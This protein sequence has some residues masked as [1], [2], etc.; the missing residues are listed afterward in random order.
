M[1]NIT[2]IFVSFFYIGYLKIWPGSF[3]SAASIII[4]FSILSFDILSKVLFIILFIIIFFLSLYF[5]KIFSSYTKTH[6]SGIIV[7]DEFLGIYLIL[8]FYDLIIFISPI[9]TLI[10]AFM[11]FRFFDILK[12]YPANLI[13]KKMNNSLGVILDD[14]VAAI[15]TIISIY[16]L[17]VVN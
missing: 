17:N 8:I 3:A 2:K 11:L 12:I 16:I 9:V 4:L 1:M 6:D 7:I 14:I 5:I 10:I 15:Y 13:D